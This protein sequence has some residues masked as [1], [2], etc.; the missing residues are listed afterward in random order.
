VRVATSWAHRF[1]R[2]RTDPRCLSRDLIADFLDALDRNG[3][4]L[5]T[6]EEALAVH[7]LI[8]ALLESGRTGGPAA[9]RES[10]ATAVSGGVYDR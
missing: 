3:E 5:V 6:G 10:D 1:W 7:F 8:D 2:A 9:A 4:P